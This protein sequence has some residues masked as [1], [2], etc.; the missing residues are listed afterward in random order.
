[1]LENGNDALSGLGHDQAR[2]L[3]LYLQHEELRF[4]HIIVGCIPRQRETADLVLASYPSC[5]VTTGE[6]LCD[7]RWNEFDLERVFDDVVPQL[8]A[9]DD[10]FRNQYELLCLETGNSK[11]SVHRKWTAVHERVMSAWIEDRYPSRCESWC[12]FVAR[13]KSAGSSFRRFGRHAKIA[14]FT[15][16]TPIAIWVS[17]AFGSETPDH[18]TALATA[19]LTSSITVLRLRDT[20]MGL[21]SFNCIPH[22]VE[23]NMRVCR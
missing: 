15:S 1:M 23:P 11:L 22:L 18:I 14:V 2:L 4:D 16:A 6:L 20:R 9:D 8:A 12:Q 7:E 19:S 10:I 3:A 5:T 17:A 21:E 13:V